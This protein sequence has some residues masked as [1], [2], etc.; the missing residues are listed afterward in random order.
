VSRA[1]SQAGAEFVREID[2]R[3][4]LE[5]IDWLDLCEDLESILGRAVGHGAEPGSYPCW[6][7]SALVG[8]V[9]QHGFIG[10]AEA[11]GLVRYAAMPRV[12]ARQA[13]RE[14]VVR[15]GV[16]KHAESD[17]TGAEAGGGEA[18]ADGEAGGCIR[19]R[20]DAEDGLDPVDAGEPAQAFLFGEEAVI[21]PS[22][23]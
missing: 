3:L 14:S 21:G 22:R 6:C 8:G 15:T 12:A 16:Y 23:G 11:K 18:G 20:D 2:L 4:L 13:E 7:F 10:V 17:G 1:I 19:I 9:F 5:R